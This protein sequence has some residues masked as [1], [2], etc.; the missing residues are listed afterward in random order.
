VVGSVWAIALCAGCDSGQRRGEP[1]G[2]ETTAPLHPALTARPVSIPARIAA[3]GDTVPLTPKLR[4]AFNHAAFEPM[5]EPGPNDWLAQHPEKPQ[6]F[7]DYL[8]ADRNEATWA[9]ARATWIRN[10]V[11]RVG[12]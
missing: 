3:I 4:R 1:P 9:A 2:K 11:G 8:C 7:E 6:S 5:P 12:P 10:G